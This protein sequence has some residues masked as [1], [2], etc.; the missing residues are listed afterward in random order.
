MSLADMVAGYPAQIEQLNNTISQIDAQIA[1][2]NE[3]KVSLEG[4]LTTMATS[5]SDIFEAK[6]PTKYFHSYGGYGVTNITDFSVCE[7]VTG[8]TF[9]S[10]TE[11]TIS[12]T[13]LFLDG[14]VAACNCGV[15]GI[16]HCTISGAPSG[17]SVT[18][19]GD[20]LTINLVDARPTIYEYEGIGWDS[21]PDYL[22]VKDVFDFT[23]NYLNKPMG[24]EGT[25]GVIDMIAKMEQ[26]KG[27][28]VSNEGNTTSAL[29]KYGGLV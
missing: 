1:V 7:I 4:V 18:V 29:E 13:S 25:Y 17:S 21:D 10:G 20:P 12:D 3:Q 2:L 19:T 6:F 5:A 8:A 14:K 16:K 23:Y 9:V 15:D 26:G 11:F 28:M 22:A 27:I 24:L